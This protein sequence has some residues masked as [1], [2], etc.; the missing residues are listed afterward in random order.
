MAYE[1]DD[2][3]AEVAAEHA[4]SREQLAELRPLVERKRRELAPQGVRGH[5][6]PYDA[7]DWDGLI[8]KVFDDRNTISRGDVFD[9]AGTAEITDVFAASFMWGSGDRGYGPHRYREIVAS[10]EGRLH[11]MLAAAL[12]AAV[13]DAIDGYAMFFGGYDPKR[14][15]APNTPPWTRIDEF[16]PAFF[17]KFLYFTTS[18]ALILDNV[19]ANKVTALSEI[20][21]LVRADGRSYAWSPYRYAVYLHWMRQTAK[22]LACTPDELELTLF[23]TPWPALSTARRTSTRELG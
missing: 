20:P 17:S 10:T 21:Y 23:Q 8:P 6:V 13:E 5:R 11:D 14:R 9:L 4:V 7:A 18:G 22:R 12:M 15:A 1:Y 3:A 19:L 2:K 16:G